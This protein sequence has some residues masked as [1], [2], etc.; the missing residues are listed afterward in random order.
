[1]INKGQFNDAGVCKVFSARTTRGNYYVQRMPGSYGCGTIYRLM[2]DRKAVQCQDFESEQ[3]AIS[4]LLEHLR[5]VL[6][7]LELF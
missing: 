7:G 4:A 2:H 3:E 6:C 5:R 1:M